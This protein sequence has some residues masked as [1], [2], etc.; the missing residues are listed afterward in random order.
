MSVTQ[1]DREQDFRQLSGGVLGQGLGVRDSKT[2]GPHRHDRN[3]NLVC[4]SAGSCN[5]GLIKQCVLT[6]VLI[7]QCLPPQ[8]KLTCE[9]QRQLD[10]CD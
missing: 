8:C 4:T 5:H 6:P 10:C 9:G 2:A 1:P 7:S 3:R